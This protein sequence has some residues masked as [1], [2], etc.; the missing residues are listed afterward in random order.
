MH[1]KA[2]LVHTHTQVLECH[3]MAV[4]QHPNPLLTSRHKLN[5]FYPGGCTNRLQVSKHKVLGTK[6]EVTASL[7]INDGANLWSSRA[8]RCGTTPNGKPRRLAALAQEPFCFGLRL[9]M[10]QVGDQHSSK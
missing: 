9:A 5:L 6:H 1:C 3:S 10:Q 4:A 8:G 2:S 7:A